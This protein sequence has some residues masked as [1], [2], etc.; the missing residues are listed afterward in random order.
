[1]KCGLR[2]KVPPGVS[3][4][5]VKGAEIEFGLAI[6]SHC[7]NLL[8][9]TSRPR[10]YKEGWKHTHTREFDLWTATRR[11]TTRT[12]T[13][14][15]II[16]VSSGPDLQQ[17]YAALPGTFSLERERTWPLKENV[18]L[19][20]QG[21]LS[22]CGEG[23]TR[24]RA[25]PRSLNYTIEPFSSCL[26]IQ[27]GSQTG[28]NLRLVRRS[29]FESFTIFSPAEEEIKGIQIYN[30]IGFNLVYS[31]WATLNK[32]MRSGY[33]SGAGQLKHQMSL[34]KQVVPRY[35]GSWHFFLPF[36]RCMTA[37]VGTF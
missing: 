24:R 25:S 4:A 35:H 14:N 15:L 11:V 33:F 32:R 27:R 12:S 3:C 17:W 19:P 26:I 36:I 20:Y 5:E 30:K 13:L 8:N 7:S 6:I 28:T 22:R 16:D 34:M 1:M 31:M 18:W 23:F 37:A 21:R 29:T 2:V 10:Y 9:N